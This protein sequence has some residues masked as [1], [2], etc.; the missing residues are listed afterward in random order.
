MRSLRRHASICRRI[1][2]S[3][4][5]TSCSGLEAFRSSQGGRRPTRR[6]RSRRRRR[7]PRGR[8]TSLRWLTRRIPSS[9]RLKPTTLGPA[10]RQSRVRSGGDS[11]HRASHRFRR[12]LDQ[13]RRH[14]GESRGGASSSF[15]NGIDPSTNGAVDAADVFLGSRSIGGLPAGATSSATTVLQI[16]QTLRPVPTS[17]LASPTGTAPSRKHWRRIIREAMRCPWG[18]LG[19]ST[20][21]GS[22]GGAANGSM[23]VTDTTKNQGATV[24]QS[25]T[26][27]YFSINSTFEAADLL[28]G[29]CVALV[30][31][32]G[33]PARRRRNSRFQ[34]V[35]F[36]ARIGLSR[37][38][39]G[40]PRLPRALRAT[41][42][43]RTY[44]ALDPID[45]EH[46][47]SAD[48]SRRRDDDQRDRH[49]LESGRRYGASVGTADNSLRMELSTRETYRWY[50]HGSVV[51]AGDQPVGIC[52]SRFPHRLPSAGTSSSPRL[53][54]MIR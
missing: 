45:R 50:A 20:L 37:S 38:R 6:R 51:G 31:G 28:I 52:L 46:S 53:M 48:V 5:R 23:T 39:I 19:V 42:L 47:H 12:W 36:R 11:S 41:T 2:S 8:I 43:A 54:E 26:G 34:R 1:L 7:R 29:S 24:P 15:I 21:T 4:P 10:R 14:H 17:L 27:F 33:Y 44:S 16:P 35:Y 18:R 22:G 25:E 49:D 32:T 40:E 30:L 9:S 13:R 3:T